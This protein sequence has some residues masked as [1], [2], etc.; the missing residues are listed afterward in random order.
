MINDSDIKVYL[1]D[2][3]G[4]QL[5]G[6][7]LISDLNN[8][9]LYRSTHSHNGNSD[10]QEK[11]KLRVW[12]DETKTEDA[13][14]W[15]MDTKLQYKFRLNA[16]SDAPT[17]NLCKA[18]TNLNISTEGVITWTASGNCST[19]QHQ[20]SFDGI[21]YTNATSGTNYKNT[22]IATPGIK[23]VYVKA[24]APNEAYDGSDPAIA[25]TT[26]YSVILTK[27]TG[28]DAVTGAGN[29]IKGANV[30]IDATVNNDYTWKNWTKTSGGSQ[31]STTK[32]YTAAIKN[33]W[34]YTANGI[35]S[36]RTVN[37]TVN[38][39]LIGGDGNGTKKVTINTSTSFTIEPSSG[40]TTVG[41]VPVCT[42][43][44]TAT[45][46]GNTLTT[47]NITSDT[48]CTVTLTRVTA[49]KVYFNDADI[50]S[51]CND[52]QCMIE[53]IDDILSR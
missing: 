12:I 29:Y 39:G 14:N 13:R 18:P 52:V 53:H 43:G 47:G 10:V 20:I 38:N 48:T 15:D 22:L 31:V 2:Y 51:S 8:Y 35:I 40:Y 50:N 9:V 34:D 23:K 17:N 36:V 19:A 30:S 7:T 1:E 49:D 27:G 24:V 16:G 28:I 4:N 45:I 25:S 32:A 5:V 6:P 11:F 41:V 42:N 3:E 44:Q 21:N 46:S 37:L 26:V 33:N